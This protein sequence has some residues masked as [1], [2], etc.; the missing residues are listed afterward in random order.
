VVNAYDHYAEFYGLT[1]EKPH[2][3]RVDRIQRIPKTEDINRIISHVRLKYAVCYSVMRDTG[4]RPSE[5]SRLRVKDIYREQ[6]LV[7]PQSAKHGSGRVLKLLKSTVAMLNR[8]ISKYG[9]CEKDFLG[10]NLKQVRDN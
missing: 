8:Y 10:E 7:Y 1:W 3:D 6:G 2:Y 4:I 9:L 5:A